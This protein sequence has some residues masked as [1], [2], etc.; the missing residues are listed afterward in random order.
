[1]RFSIRTFALAIVL[2]SHLAFSLQA[3]GPVFVFSPFG[4]DDD[5]TMVNGLLKSKSLTIVNFGTAPLNVSSAT[6]SGSEFTFNPSFPIPVPATIPPNGT[7]GPFVVVFTPS[8]PG[9]R[10]GQILVQDDAPGN[11][12]TIPLQ[13]FGVAVAPGDFAVLGQHNSVIGTSV[14][15]GATAM[16][17]LVVTGSPNTIT[18]KCSGAPQAAACNV[19]PS[20][21]LSTPSILGSDSSEMIQVS[22]STTG[23]GQFASLRPARLALWSSLAMAFGLALAVGHK[24]GIRVALLTLCVSTMLA[25]IVT[26][27]GGSNVTNGLISTPPGTYTLTLTA[28]GNGGTGT[29]HTVPITLGVRPSGTP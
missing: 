25:G 4:L 21:A 24:R 28:T 7:L 2:Y 26:C 12:H 10:T 9:V 1:V 11:P 14:P 6:I 8:G 15:A 23:T 29:V 3:G 13:G 5:T 18:L 22:V 20:V 19:Q 27:G 16:Y 17:S